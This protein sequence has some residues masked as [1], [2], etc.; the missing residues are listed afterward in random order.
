[1][2][3]MDVPSHG[4]MGDRNG[5]EKPGLKSRERGINQ[6][7]IETQVEMR[8]KTK[9]KIS[10]KQLNRLHPRKRILFTGRALRNLSWRGMRDGASCSR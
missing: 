3:M 2:L 6:P 1:M 8:L 4:E 7:A 5:L 9:M 10:S